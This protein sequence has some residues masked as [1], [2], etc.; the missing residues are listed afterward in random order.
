MRKTVLSF[1]ALSLV[2]SLLL[3]FPTASAEITQTA[4]YDWETVAEIDFESDA[5]FDFYQNNKNHT[6][7]E[8]YKK[9]ERDENQNQTNFYQVW[10]YGVPLR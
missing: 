5:Q 7:S 2:L 9:G 6:E 4:E 3:A 10:R 1:I 8:V